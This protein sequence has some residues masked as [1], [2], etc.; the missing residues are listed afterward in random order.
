[1]IDPSHTKPKHLLVAIPVAA[2][3]GGLVA[4]L[5]FGVHEP[6]SLEYLLAVPA[7]I[8]AGLYVLP[9]ALVA[10]VAGYFALRRLRL[11]N[12]VSCAAIGLATGL[13]V[14]AVDPVQP[15]WVFLCA[16]L[17]LTSA[18][19]AYGVLWLLARRGR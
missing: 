14:A 17:G 2:I 16:A 13:A 7:A 5:G 12:A 9:I 18:L 11:L 10:G 15:F 8:V 6:P 4:T 3:A 1:M 19:A